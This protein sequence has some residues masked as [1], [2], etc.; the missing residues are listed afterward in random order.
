[1]NGE[2]VF[3]EIEIRELL[4]RRE[5]QYHEFKSLWDRSGAAPRPLDRK[6]V[7]DWIA[8]YVA[9]FA[10]ADG[11]TILLGVENDG[12]PSGH[13][14]PEEEI[15]KF[16]DVSKARL[17]PP[18]TVRFQRMPIDGQEILLLE[19][20][21]SPDAVMVIGDGFPYRINDQVIKEPQEAIRARKHA[22][23]ATGFERRE[24]ADARLEDLDLDLASQLFAKTIWRGGDTVDTLERYG[25]VVMKG[26]KRAVTNA[27]LLLFGK[28]PL[29]RW[30]PRAGIRLFKVRGVKRK[31]GE[32]R[33]VAQL[34]RLEAPLAELVEKAK[35][36]AEG[37][38]GKSEIL[39]DL[40]FREMPEYP[41]FA[42][43]EAIV[44]AVA[45]R[46]YND[47][48]REIEI[49][50]YDDRMEIANPGELV[51]P[52]TLEALQECRQIHASRNPILVRVLAEAGIMREE[53]EG[54][55]RMH[56]EMRKSHLRPPAFGAANSTFT[57]TLFNEPVFSSVPVARNFVAGQMMVSANQKRALLMHWPKFTNEQYRS[58]NNLD[59]DQA[60]REIQELV[61]RKVL[62]PATGQGRGAAYT[63]SKS[64]TELADWL[65]PVLEQLTGFFSQSG[66]LK[67]SDYQVLFSVTRIAATRQLKRLVELRLLRRMGTGKG[68]WYGPT[69]RLKE[70]KVSVPEDDGDA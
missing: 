67:N 27:A 51:P 17:E 29:T 15:A 47:T 30:H 68:T 26:R 42:W 44:N 53:G 21:P 40:F 6:K 8:E 56:D 66:K 46:D 28:P 25:L 24:A 45:H 70:L 4:K 18:L 64:W 52:V 63:I 19:V 41:T 55:P 5:G 7:R 16:V 1:M 14:Y 58:V 43:Q 34:P 11:G 10:N 61:A 65:Q 60:Y 32:E 9:A 38:I 12:T 23:R 2:T 37:Q 13:S 36:Q 49:T 50:F 22:Y 57:V 54:V 62:A 33:N 35:R 31:H 3:T 59:R 69:E 48:T 20:P 39:H